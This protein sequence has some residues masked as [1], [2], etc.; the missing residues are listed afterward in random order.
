MKKT[1]LFL[2]FISFGFYAPH[3]YAY[4]GNNTVEV[5]FQDPSAENLPP[6]PNSEAQTSIDERN[7]QESQA[8][9]SPNNNEVEIQLAHEDTCQR[10]HGHSGC[11]HGHDHGTP[12][13]IV[14][15]QPYP[16][17][18]ICRKGLF[19]CINYYAQPVGSG[20]TCYDIFGNV[21]FYGQ[22]SVF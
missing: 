2:F 8:I 4:V 16:V 10:Q 13:I 7:N 22:N 14:V 1:V 21:W 12:N 18:T 19:Y 9:T 15:P 6:P 3:I 20:C 17:S 5:E 11:G